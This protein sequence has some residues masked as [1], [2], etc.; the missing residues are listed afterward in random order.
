MSSMYVTSMCIGTS[1]QNPGRKG[2]QAE[3][4]LT[5]R[6]HLTDTFQVGLLSSLTMS[7][8]MQFGATDLLEPLRTLQIYQTTRLYYLK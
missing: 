3:N 4:L 1:S 8:M 2:V 7:I 5:C 6:E